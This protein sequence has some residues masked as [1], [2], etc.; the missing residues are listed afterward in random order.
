MILKKMVLENFRQYYGKHE[1]EF[2]DDNRN[3]T[4]ILGVNNAGTTSLY[5]ALI[6]GL[7]GD[8]YLNQDDQSRE[9]HLVNMRALK[10]RQ[11]VKAIVTIEIEVDKGTYI[12][13]RE[14]K[15]VST[16]G[17]ISE[18]EG[19]LKLD[20]I[21]KEGEFFADYKVDSD[22]I[23]E[24]I[25]EILDKNIKEF[26]LFDGEKI[27]TL[28][29]ADKNSRKE[30]KEGIIKLMKIDKLEFIRDIIKEISREEN[31]R[32]SHRSS[33][34]DIHE[35]EKEITEMNDNID[36]I[37]EILEEKRN[38]I[39]KLDI[40]IKNN[41]D[42]LKENEELRNLF[43]EKNILEKDLVNKE[44][45]LKVLQESLLSYHFQN[46]SSLVM[47]DHY[48]KLERILERELLTQDDLIPIQV[49]EK[50]LESGKCLCC[51]QDIDDDNSLEFLQKI[52][53]NYKPS[54]ITR[55]ME[56]MDRELKSALMKKES[57]IEKLGKLL[58]NISVVE[59][60]II[61]IQ[62]NL[63]KI[64]EKIKETN[65]ETNSQSLKNLE[66]IY[67]KNLLDKRMDEEK[68]IE[69][70]ERKESILKEKREKE[71]RCE[72]LLSEEKGIKYEI[73]RLTFLNGFKEKIEEIYDKYIDLTRERLGEE[74]TETFKELIDYTDLSLVREVCINK[75]YEID[76]K[77]GNK[78]VTQDISQ[79]Q[80]MI[81]AL[82]FITS[83]AKLASEDKEIVEFPLFMDTPFGRLS[84]ENRKNLIEKL[85]DL[86]KQWIP[87]LTDTDFTE[88]EEKIFRESGRVGKVYKINKLTETESELEDITSKWEE[89]NGLFI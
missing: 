27:E 64:N 66:E 35:L 57:E 60:D 88:F 80:Q 55:F 84:K 54:K 36:K 9:V 33:N 83:L 30:V 34:N 46:G 44:S 22:E 8:R 47:S 3:T 62:N 75:N 20:F 79:G 25:N 37:S 24:L 68:V 61:G 87:L 7:Y 58:K 72:K 67:Q 43:E 77:Y 6:Y 85:P 23:Q 81:V 56:N 52:K 70:E 13:T 14:L 29:R 21:S 74:T 39:D 16:Q 1:I 86:T 4:L 42:K 69:L 82:S 38:N 18:R 11:L 49:I 76:I 32:L 65:A 59:K 53:L 89:E 78:E 48:M 5:R 28:A 71:L 19:S 12:I 17:Q 40:E 26:F 50:T 31:K 51:N 63:E 15:G 41:E 2:T 10:E 45:N 73:S